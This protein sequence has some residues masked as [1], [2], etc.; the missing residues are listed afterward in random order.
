M[1]IYY[2]DSYILTIRVGELLSQAGLRLLKHRHT[3]RFLVAAGTRHSYQGSRV[4]GILSLVST[5]R[6]HL[7][8]TCDPPT[9]RSRKVDEANG[10]P[11]SS[12]QIKFN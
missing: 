12:L 1:I 7:D 3:Y 5:P 8:Q 6:L 4:S 2:Y 11:P 10:P 9:A